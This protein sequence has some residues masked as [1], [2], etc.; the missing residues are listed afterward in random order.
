MDSLIYYAALIAAVIIG[1]ILIK[2]FVSCLLRTI[3]TLVLVAI[4][5]YIYYNFLR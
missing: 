5:A 3:V 2:R 1:V 4:F